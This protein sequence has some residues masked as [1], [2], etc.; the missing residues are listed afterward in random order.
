VLHPRTLQRFLGRGWEHGRRVPDRPPAVHAP[1]R[2]EARPDKLPE[3]YAAVKLYFN[4][5]LPDTS[6]SRALLQQTI[7]RLAAQTDVV[8]LPEAVGEHESFSP[9]RG[10]RVHPVT[11]DP[12]HNLAVQAQILRHASVLVSTYGGFS[13]LG[14]YVGTPTLALYSSAPH[15][16]AHLDLVDRIGRRLGNGTPLYRA[17]HVGAL[18]QE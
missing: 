12:K 11:F 4:A 15:G 9:Q 8:V 3:R 14:P 1:L 10:P 6:E 13:F 2:A 7:E 18:H 17:R 16:I 5:S